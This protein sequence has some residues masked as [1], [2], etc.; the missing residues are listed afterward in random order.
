V[1]SNRS[2]NHDFTSYSVSEPQN[3]LIEGSNIIAV[4]VVNQ[5]IGNSSDCFIDIRLTGETDQGASEDTTSPPDQGPRKYEIDA[6]WESEEITDPEA[7]TVAIPAGVLHP[8]RT[9]R[10]RCRMKNNIDHWSHWSAPV[11]FIAGEPLS[12]GV[13]TDLRITELMYNP[14]DPA[15]GKN[16]DDY[17]FIE[18]KNLG[19]SSLD[20]THVSFTDG[21]TFDFE[22]ATVT[23]IQPGQF[24]LVVSD[25][26]AFESRYGQALSPVIAGE[27]SGRFA[28][29]GERVVLVDDWDGTIAEFEY[30][31]GGNWP[32]LADGEGHS[33]VPVDSGLAD[34]ADG[35]LNDAANWRASTNKGGSPGMDDP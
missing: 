1:T 23:Q 17:E 16:N 2:E 20:L 35:S 14:A 21:I 34:Q 33:L 12:K 19:D 30:D 9:Y 10:V 27:Y 8:G 7:T 5:S 11:E 6:V 25:I 4:Q 31:D 15:D 22:D 13:A 3:I 24:I 32:D 18:L 28:N 26:G 29:E